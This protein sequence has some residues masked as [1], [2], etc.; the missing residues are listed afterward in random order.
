M[1]GSVK[2]PVVSRSERFVERLERQDL[3]LERRALQVVRANVGESRERPRRTGPGAPGPGRP[4]QMDGPTASRILE[5]VAMTPGVRTLEITGDA[6]ELNPWF[7]LLVGGGRELG[8]EVIDRSDL[9]TLSEPGQ[10]DLPHFLRR[11][12]VRIVGSLPGLTREAVDARRGRGGFDRLVRSLRRL[13]EH[14]YGRGDG[15]LRL[16]VVYEPS[17][18]GP[19]G[20]P[21]ALEAACRKRLRA[22]HG[23]D[24]DRLLPGA[25][26]PAHRFRRDPEREGALDE[27]LELL[28]SRFD[29][30][31][32][33]EV[34]CRSLISVA[35]DGRLY[36]CDL[37]RVLGVA[38]GDRPRSVWS[39]ESF[40]ELAGEPIA[41]GDHC[42]ACTVGQGGSRGGA[43]S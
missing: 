30:R 31:A 32:V 28:A 26:L 15:A 40:A 38:A 6:P 1:S 24:F 12:R 43:S 34:T 21:E 14:G 8:L 13:N 36:D 9:V 2:R 3:R 18:S 19:S 17:D 33:E 16:D 11:H 22:E 7:R 4:H 37:N 35:W 27:L 23:V 5:L 41:F 25:V 29:P 20:D 39:I 10:E 42:Y